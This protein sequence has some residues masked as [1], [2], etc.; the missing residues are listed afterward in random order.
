MS[1]ALPA[2]TVVTTSSEPREFSKTTAQDLSLEHSSLCGLSEQRS[3][4]SKI[5]LSIFT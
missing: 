3:S 2:G 1:H 5:Q 4:L